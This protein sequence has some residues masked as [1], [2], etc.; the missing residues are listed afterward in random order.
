MR[1]DRVAMTIRQRVQATAVL[2]LAVCGLMAGAAAG[3]GVIPA[4]APALLAPAV[5]Y[6]V[7]GLAALKLVASAG[8][9]LAYVGSKL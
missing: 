5:G 2:V 6:L 9:V 3:L 1:A 4:A 7:A 8:A